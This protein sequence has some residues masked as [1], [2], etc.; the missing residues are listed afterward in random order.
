MEKEW[1]SQTEGRGECICV[2]EGG[3]SSN[4]SLER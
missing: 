4:L 1:P 2:N 3:E